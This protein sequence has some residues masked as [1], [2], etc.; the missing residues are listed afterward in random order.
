MSSLLLILLA[1]V[2]ISRYAPVLFGTRVFAETDDYSNWVGVALASSTLIATVAAIAYG[3]DHLILR[4]FAVGYLQTFVVVIMIMTLAPVFAVLMPQLGPWT[5]VHPPF[6][7]VLI[8]N[9]AVLGTALQS[10]VAPNFSSAL[11]LGIGMGAAFAVLLLAFTTLHARVATARVPRA[12]REMPVALVT[13]GLM[14][15]ALMGLTGIV[16]D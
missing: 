3:I 15:L 6:V 13:V 4:P 5:P 16:R 11:W 8:T 7:L 10:A 12:F 14:A 2:L 1:A 9:P